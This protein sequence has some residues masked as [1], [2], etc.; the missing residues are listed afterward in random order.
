MSC[1]VFILLALACRLASSSKHNS[2]TKPQGTWQTQTHYLVSSWAEES[3]FGLKGPVEIRAN[4]S[5]LQRRF[6]FFFFFFF[7]FCFCSCFAPHPVWGFWEFL[8]FL[9]SYFLNSFYSLSHDLTHSWGDEGIPTFLKSSSV[10]M[11]IKV[12]LEIELAYYE[13]TI[14]HAFHCAMMIPHPCIVFDCIECY[15]LV[16]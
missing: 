9:N 2:H 14:L 12:W 7:F 16:S 4:L 13:V 15:T 1:G 8:H 5:F 11:D 6:L 3:S 10:N